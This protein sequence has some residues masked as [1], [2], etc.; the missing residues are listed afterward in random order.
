M[1]LES[2]GREGEPWT[3]EK[4]G[5][6]REKK[7]GIEETLLAPKSTSRLKKKRLSHELQGK[8]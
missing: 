2:T 3:T 4:D 1:V 5:I 8:G 7:N 6:W